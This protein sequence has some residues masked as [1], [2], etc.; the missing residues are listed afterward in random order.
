MWM[1]F[2]YELKEPVGGLLLAGESDGGENCG[3]EPWVPSLGK[4]GA[5][6]LEGFKRVGLGDS[7]GGFGGSIAPSAWR[8]PPRPDPA[9][10]TGEVQA[11]SGVGGRAPEMLSLY[12]RLCLKRSRTYREFEKMLCVDLYRQFLGKSLVG[13]GGME[14]DGVGVAPMCPY[15][16]YDYAPYNC[17]PYGYYGQQ[18]ESPDTAEIYPFCGQIRS[19]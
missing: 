5:Q 10:N 8:P 19:R 7:H 2:F 11:G 16:Y 15:G 13:I 3:P 18:E 12:V 1:F 14:T 9:L 17:S 6:Q 4:R